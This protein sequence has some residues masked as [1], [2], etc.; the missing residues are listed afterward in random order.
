MPFAQDN[1]GTIKQRSGRSIPPINSLVFRDGGLNAGAA[2]HGVKLR[3]DRGGDQVLDEITGM[4]ASL[5]DELD[6]AMC[7]LENAAH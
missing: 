7:Q 6:E 3:D 2:T 1:I 4:L 5:T